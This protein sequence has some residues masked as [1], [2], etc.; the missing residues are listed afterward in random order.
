MLVVVEPRHPPAQRVRHAPPSGPRRFPPT[1][2]R[3]NP[4]PDE[5][6]GLVDDVT[7]DL[8]DQYTGVLVVD[9]VEIPEDQLDRVVGHPE[10]ELPA[11]PR[12][13]HQPFRAGVNDVVVK[14][15]N[16]RTAGPGPAKPLSYS[17]QFRASA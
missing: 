3:V 11:R 12:Q 7:V 9:G 1:S 17:W 15:W 14:Y 16:G 6:T 13:G 8:A 2:R 5:L 10:R 4:E